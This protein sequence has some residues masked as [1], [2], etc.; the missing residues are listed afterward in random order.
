MHDDSIRLCSLLELVGEMSHGDVDLAY[1]VREEEGL[2]R[3]REVN[4]LGWN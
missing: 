3:E 4:K 2:E 1:V